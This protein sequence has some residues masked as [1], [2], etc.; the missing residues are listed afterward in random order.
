MSHLGPRATTSDGGG[1]QTHRERHS[2][3]LLYC[4]IRLYRKSWTRSRRAAVR[5]PFVGA[6]GTAKNSE[7]EFPC[8]VEAKQAD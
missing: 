4:T 5:V 2:A 8:T 3:H 1:E 6:A 7:C